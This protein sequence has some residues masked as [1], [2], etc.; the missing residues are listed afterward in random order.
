ME[1]KS[2]TPPAVDYPIYDLPPVSIGADCEPLLS[3]MLSAF[4]SISE[5]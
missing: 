1:N 5:F 2:A 4:E 3:Q